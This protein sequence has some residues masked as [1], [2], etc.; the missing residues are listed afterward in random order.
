MNVV[1]LYILPVV[2]TLCTQQ[3]T[4]KLCSCFSISDN[5]ES[6]LFLAANEAMKLVEVFVIELIKYSLVI[7]KLR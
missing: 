4:I 1:E 5:N 7:K 3:I 2:K 6:R